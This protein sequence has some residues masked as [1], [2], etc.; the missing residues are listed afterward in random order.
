MAT[1]PLENKK[2]RHEGGLTS[3]ESSGPGGVRTPDLMTASHAR[4]QLR[5]RPDDITHRLYRNDLRMVNAS[6]SA[7]VHDVR[8]TAKLLVSIPQ[9]NLR[10]LISDLRCRIR[11][12]SRF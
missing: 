12:I 9:S 8:A 5:H 11:P 4:S 7:H 3:L 6:G 2:G 10:F 1:R